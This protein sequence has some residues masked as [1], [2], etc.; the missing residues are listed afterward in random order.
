MKRSTK[1]AIVFLSIILIILIIIIIVL[2]ITNKPVKEESQ[3]GQT[4]IAQK[5]TEVIEGVTTAAAEE[6]AETTTA[7]AT[8]ADLPNEKEV[9]LYIGSD[10]QMNL[11]TEYSSV[12][13]VDEDIASFEAINSTEDT[14]YY[15]DY[16]T[17]HSDYWNAVDTDVT[18]KIGYELSFDVGGEH[19]VYTILKPA[20][21]SD[22]PDLFMGEAANDVVTG[23]MGVWV[24]C[25]IGQTGT[26]IHLTQADMQA[27]TL[28]TSIKLRPTPQSSEISNFK[29]KAFSYTS[30][31][32]FDSDGHY[33]GTHGYEI[34]IYNQ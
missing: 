16:Y 29:L 34:P 20:D 18:Y 31:A 11:V 14:I 9:R 4:V 10:G 33:I 21:I 19:K 25:D 1:K 13:S 5:A 8:V 30:D 3:M 28:M 12:W 15:S 32:E 7:E 24:Y 23:Y 17:L 27:D 2:A 26:Y 22:N 6:E